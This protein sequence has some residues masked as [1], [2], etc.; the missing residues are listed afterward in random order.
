M[1]RLAPLLSLQSLGVE[2]LYFRLSICIKYILCSFA[3]GLI[4]VRDINGATPCIFPL[5][6]GCICLRMI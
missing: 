6:S 1:I 5:K 3:N 4:F 2:C